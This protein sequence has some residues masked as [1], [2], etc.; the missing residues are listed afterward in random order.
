MAAIVE[1]HIGGQVCFRAVGLQG[2]IKLAETPFSSSSTSLSTI[3]GNFS[4]D[5]AINVR[6]TLVSFTS[7]QDELLL[8]D[9]H[10]VVMERGGSSFSTKY[11]IAVAASSAAIIIANNDT[12]NPDS[13]LTPCGVLHKSEKAKDGGIIIFYPPLLM[14]SYNSSVNLKEVIKSQGEK[15]VMYF[16][17]RPFT[18]QDIQHSVVIGHFGAILRGCVAFGYDDLVS[19]LLNELNNQK[20]TLE[21][22]LEDIE[23]GRGATSLHIG[24][25]YGR[26]IIVAMLLKA[27]AN[28][29]SIKSDGFSPLQIA[30]ELGNMECISLLLSS[31][32]YPNHP[33]PVG[34]SSLHTASK[35]G[36]L[37]ICKVLVDAGADINYLSIDDC[38]ALH[39][40]CLYGHADIVSYLLKCGVNYHI[41]NKNGNNALS[42]AALIKNTECGNII[43]RESAFV[44]QRPI[45]WPSHLYFSYPHNRNKKLY[46]STQASAV[47]VSFDTINICMLGETWLRKLEPIVTHLATEAI[48]NSNS[49]DVEKISSILAIDIDRCCYVEYRSGP[50]KIV[51]M[52]TALALIADGRIVYKQGLLSLL[53]VLVHVFVCDSDVQRG[54]FCLSIEKTVQ[55]FH[56]MLFMFE[57]LKTYYTSNASTDDSN[58]KSLSAKIDVFSFSDVFDL[59]FGILQYLH[60]EVFSVLAWRNTHPSLFALPWLSTL[61][62]DLC[63]L[64][65][66]AIYWSSLI[67]IYIDEVS[68]IQSAN[69]DVWKSYAHLRRIGVRLLAAH[70]T[71]VLVQY[72]SDILCGKIIKYNT[73]EDVVSKHFLF[74]VSEALVDQEK[75]LLDVIESYP[76]IDNLLLLF[77]SINN[78]EDGEEDGGTAL[79][80]KVR[81]RK[82]TK[83]IDVLT[84]AAD[85]KE[86][87]R[88]VGDN[89]LTFRSSTNERCLGIGNV[90][91]CLTSSM[92]L[93]IDQISAL[94]SANGLESCIIVTMYGRSCDARRVLE[95][96]V[97]EL[98]SYFRQNNRV[99]VSSMHVRDLRVEGMI[100]YYRSYA[101][102]LCTDAFESRRRNSNVWTGVLADP[103]RR[104]PLFSKPFYDHALERGIDLAAAIIVIVPFTDDLKG[105][106]QI[107]LAEEFAACLVTCGQPHTVILK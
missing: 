22:A 45:T 53:A 62:A 78:P 37:Q 93:S 85:A 90:W 81:S 34:W 76:N 19:C 88:M 11:E 57:P 17:T 52:Q 87:L 105:R 77:A 16:S 89:L 94:L 35:A 21:V 83:P 46:K 26:I 75:L 14:I 80:Q 40:A 25:E 31:G 38:T 59:S 6:S 60:P 28:T 106:G 20:R 9:G 47:K 96:R 58:Y 44:P 91:K 84:V 7:P 55:M 104:R 98:E 107:M 68:S 50:R 10:V 3:V 1:L 39:I 15:D 100:A 82:V 67:D 64:S 12:D 65:E 71:A 41:K 79:M 49:N 29:E 99:S 70:V 2:R 54:E 8:F 102:S 36:N 5:T 61:L 27:G 72:S 66:T 74:P 4:G 63:P 73:H 18:L 56:I 43:K 86:M 51:L 92:Y 23:I 32:A 103:P 24:I 48:K 33:H 30:V 101:Q 42:L 13:I 69:G 95:G 97:T